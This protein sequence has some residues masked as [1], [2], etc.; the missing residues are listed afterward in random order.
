MI[1]ERVLAHITADK[2]DI[3]IQAAIERCIESVVER[4]LNT[5]ANSSNYGPGLQTKVRE[6][7]EAHLASAVPGG[8]D[9]HIAALVKRNFSP[10]KEAEFVTIMQKRISQATNAH[11]GYRVEDAV[12][13]AVEAELMRS[14]RR[15]QIS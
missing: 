2:L 7:V 8:L 6:K 10:K 15:T 1:Y 3:L 9:G 12:S 13:S 14:S 4:A 11:I 5:F